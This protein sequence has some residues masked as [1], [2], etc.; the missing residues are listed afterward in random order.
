VIRDCR[1]ANEE[2]L[3]RIDYADLLALA[4]ELGLLDVQR[5]IDSF[6]SHSA[7]RKLRSIV[8]FSDGI[9]VSKRS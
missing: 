8:F 2:N 3:A 4:E 6:A 5:G 7:L 1:S 9:L